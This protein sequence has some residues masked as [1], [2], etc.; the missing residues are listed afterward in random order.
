MTDTKKRVYSLQDLQ[1]ITQAEVIGDPLFTVEGVDSLDTA[2]EKEVSLFSN[3][4]YYKMYKQTQAGVICVD[5]QAPILPGKNYLISDNPSE[6]F[7]KIISLFK[8]VDDT[9]GFLGIHPTAVVH[10][11]ATVAKSA[12]IGP[13]AVVD[14]G[15]F[16]GENT[17]VHAHVFIGPHVSV[18]KNCI[19]HPRSV[20]QRQCL[21]GNG[22]ILQPGAVIGSCGYGYHTNKEGR[23]TKIHHF[24]NV[25]L[26]DDVEIGANTTIDRGR[27]KETRIRRGS[28]IDNL[29]MIAHNVEIG[30]DNLI[31]SQS[32]F[33]G[34]SKTG[35]RVVVGGQVGVV[36]HISI[37][38]DTQLAART[39]PVKSITKSGIYGGAPALPAKE[40]QKQVVVSRNIAS[41]AERLKRL[42]KLVNEQYVTN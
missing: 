8:E 20:V 27:F 15:A 19:L 16:V 6:I 4:R 39:A 32:G 10:Q 31:V 1:E 34:S 7:Q 11:T 23:H 18:G 22:V 40:F 17:I 35:K 14:K 38:D 29:V 9:S 12:S 28:K 33:S 41:L 21:L 25:V 24:G 2:T 26:E 13:Y 36:G 42:E 5:K 37:T 3:M 30:E